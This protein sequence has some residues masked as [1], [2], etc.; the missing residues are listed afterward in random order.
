MTALAWAKA[1]W[2]QQSDMC[3]NWQSFTKEMR[4]GFDHPISG[5]SAALRLIVLLQGSRS[6]ADYAIDIRTLAAESS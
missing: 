4:I 5:S 2:E 6:V 1:I 3:F